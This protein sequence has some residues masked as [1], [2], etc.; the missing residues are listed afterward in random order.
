[1][2]IYRP[3]RDTDASAL[4]AVRV[5]SREQSQEEAGWFILADETLYDSNRLGLQGIGGTWVV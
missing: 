1:M 3:A 5:G 2:N 4:L